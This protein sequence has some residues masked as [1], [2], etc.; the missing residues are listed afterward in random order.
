[1][2][3]AAAVVRLLAA[4]G[5]IT[6]PP[7]RSDVSPV[8]EEELAAAAERLGRA[9]GRPLSEIILSDRGDR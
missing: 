9:P 5:L 8:S 7:C 3:D 2:A 1:M 4:E 6:P